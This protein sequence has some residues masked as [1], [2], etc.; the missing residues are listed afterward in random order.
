MNIMSII[1]YVLALLL[2]AYTFIS[3]RKTKNRSSISGP[4]R[5]KDSLFGSLSPNKCQV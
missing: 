2:A 4:L 1:V 3:K 5:R